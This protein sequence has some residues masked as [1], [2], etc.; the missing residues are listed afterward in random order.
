MA[1]V[2]L[3]RP[4]AETS[5][6]SDLEASKGLVSGSSKASSG[7]SRRGGGI[8]RIFSCCK[9]CFP[10]PV[11]RLVSDWVAQDLNGGATLGDA[12]LEEVWDLYA[13]PDGKS[14]QADDLVPLVQ[15][16][17]DALVAQH[18]QRVL[19]LLLHSR[20]ENPSRYAEKMCE[21]MEGA[22]AGRISKA[23]FKGCLSSALASLLPHDDLARKE[24]VFMSL[25]ER[26]AVTMA[27][28][29]SLNF[30]REPSAGSAAGGKKKGGDVAA[31]PAGGAA[32]I[33]HATTNVG[34]SF[35]RLETLKGPMLK[36]AQDL[37]RPDQVVNKEP[38][39]CKQMPGVSVPAVRDVL[40]RD[41]WMLRQ[42]LELG[43][44]GYDFQPSKWTDGT[45]VP[46]SRIRGM[47][48]SMPTPDDIPSAVA[49]LQ[50]IPPELSASIVVRM[51]GGKDD[52]VLL[53]QTA[54]PEVPFGEN[55]EVLVTHCF[56]PYGE[57]GNAGVNYYKYAKV[58]WVK[59]PSF[60]LR[61]IKGII[62]KET[63]SKASV[64]GENFAKVL[65]Q[66]L[67]GGK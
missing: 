1:R 4:A 24:T 52:C 19:Q 32:P 26:G 18:A 23:D 2:V 30:S 13:V 16:C 31:A 37:P 28:F 36:A 60:A 49:K 57:G 7:R 61:W 25:P 12:V 39:F 65:A 56:K 11:Q 38:V 34:P 17:V 20:T 64:T 21:A 33:R 22:T 9:R 58:V 8:G 63:M 51:V 40:N 43:V 54:V 53:E 3:T 35:A 15:E 27:E 29:K 59:E 6:S 45:R 14:V 67:D 48:F 42:V 5:D 47:R 41:P 10:T 66:Q 50:K 44:K 46:G 55:F 62:E